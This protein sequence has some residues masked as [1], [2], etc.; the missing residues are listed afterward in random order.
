MPVHGTICASAGTFEHTKTGIITSRITALLITAAGFSRLR[1]STLG[2][3]PVVHGYPQRTPKTATTAPTSVLSC[4][5]HVQ[6][7]VRNG[8]PP[9][10]L[11]SSCI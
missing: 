2:C 5:Q 8:Q 7:L 11:D 1:S 4:F 6:Y 10:V 3:V 9:M